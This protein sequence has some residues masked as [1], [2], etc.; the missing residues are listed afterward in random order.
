MFDLL[1]YSRK[2]YP[3]LDQ[4]KG[5]IWFN[6]NDDVG[7]KTQNLLIIDMDNTPTTIEMF[8]YGLQCTAEIKNK[9]K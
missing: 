1:N 6:A 9:S 5:A 8:A 2:D 4:I 3:F 7:N